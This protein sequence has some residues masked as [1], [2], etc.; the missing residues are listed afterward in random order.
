MG[1]FQNKC[2]FFGKRL[3]DK[4]AKASEFRLTVA[5][6]P[7]G[8]GKSTAFRSFFPEATLFSPTPE[9]QNY[10]LEHNITEYFRQHGQLSDTSNISGLNPDFSATI[11]IDNY[12]TF[13]TPEN[14]SFIINLLAVSGKNFRIIIIANEVVCNSR[15]TGHFHGEINLL[16]FDDFALS[17]DDIA[18]YLTFLHN[19]TANANCADELL[20]A[21]GGWPVMV[22]SQASCNDTSHRALLKLRL[23]DSFKLLTAA[24]IQKSELDALMKISLIGAQFTTKLAFFITNDTEIGEKLLRICLRVLFVRIRD[25]NT[26]EIAAPFRAWLKQQAELVLSPTQ[27]TEIFRRSADEFAGNGNYSEAIA[28]FNKAGDIERVISVMSKNRACSKNDS[29]ILQSIYPKIGNEIKQKYPLSLSEIML[30]FAKNGFKKYENLVFSDLLQILQKCN[31]DAEAMRGISANINTLKLWNCGSDCVEISALD[32]SPDDISDIPGLALHGAPSVLQFFCIGNDINGTVSR[33][34][35]CEQKFAG[36]YSGAADIAAAEVQ[37]LLHNLTNAETLA[38][39]GIRRAKRQNCADIRAAGEY[40]AVK[41]Y[42]AEGKAEQAKALAEE[43]FGDAPEN[44]SARCAKFFADERITCADTSNNTDF[45][46]SSVYLYPELFRELLRRGKYCEILSFEEEANIFKEKNILLYTYCRIYL[47]V[48]YRNLGFTEKSDNIFGESLDF[49][50]KNK[51]FTI[52]AE[53]MPYVKNLIQGAKRSC[54]H[55]LSTV[56]AEY[57][58]LCNVSAGSAP[59]M[60]AEL[61]PR[62]NEIA[63]LAADGFTNSD[64]ARQLII[65]PN[66]VKATMKK[67]FGKL[68]IASR[69]KLK[70][71]LKYE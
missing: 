47:C 68:G 70:E 54:P 16:T 32:F 71:R 15:L 69:K 53:C 48:A 11:I 50:I 59:S 61:T 1:E 22:F 41:I 4:L 67:I 19:G 52:A 39:R 42:F 7:F 37:Y 49:I 44:T 60:L 35:E 30:C 33:I 8:C 24:K 57:S 63:A 20:Q 13:Q 5:E 38:I 25:E 26:F 21:S 64:I 34:R 58:K 28:L 27:K 12:H 55:E 66:T 14:D 56:C 40:L 51:F 45:L 6:A 10:S 36:I 65:S 2:V 23:F 46:Q 29:Y 18:N 3:R 62:E 31:T 17:R 43:I 9:D